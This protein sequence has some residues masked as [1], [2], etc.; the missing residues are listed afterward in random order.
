M[1]GIY[2]HIKKESALLVKGEMQVKTILRHYLIPIG[3][4][5]RREKVNEKGWTGCW[6]KQKLMY[7]CQSCEVK[8]PWYRVI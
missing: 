1:K 4:D 2:F 5:N 7:R 8:K 3:F 6:K